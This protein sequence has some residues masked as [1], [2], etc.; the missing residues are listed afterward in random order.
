MSLKNSP[1]S[2]PLDVAYQ[3]HERGWRDFVYCYPV[4]SRRSGGLSIGVN[5]NPDKACNFDCIYCQVDRST[6]G[7]V[8]KVDLGELR[9]ELDRLLDLAGSGDLYT[10]APF[11]AIRPDQRRIRDIAFSGD[12]EPT[13]C[14]QFEEAVRI[15]A[16]A[17]R[18]RGLVDTKLVLITDACYLT[19]PN[20]CAGL[21][22]LDQNNG[23][24]WAKLDAGTQEYYELV[25]RPNYPLAHVLANITDAAR[26]RP[27]VIQSLW[28]K[29]HGEPP[30]PTEITA[31]CDR[32]NEILAAGGRIKLIQ[33]YT[34]A[35]RT[36]EPFAKPL[37]DAELDSIAGSVRGCVYTRVETYYGVSG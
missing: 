19:K 14:P 16:E 35:R 5:L 23:E 7:L 25:N 1:K 13:T 28:M 18:A 17:R 11:D 3:R 30:P 2:T 22:I 33:L 10:E 34:I 32:L 36:T 24:V 4:V 31:Y 9:S 6:P 29:V 8:K 21:I 12:G 37:S 27:V 20:V 26:V 15:A